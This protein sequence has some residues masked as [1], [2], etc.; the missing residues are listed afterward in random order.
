[1]STD[2]FEICEQCLKREVHFHKKDDTVAAH[3]WNGGSERGIIVRF[4]I[5][6]DKNVPL[7]SETGQIQ[8]VNELL[9][10]IG[11]GKR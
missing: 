4:L 7:I 10:Q 1:M 6:T 2:F 8:T 11:N 9:S 5:S 3:R